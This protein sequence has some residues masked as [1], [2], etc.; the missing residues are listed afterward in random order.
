MKSYFLS[1]VMIAQSFNVNLF[2]ENIKMEKVE[3]ILQLPDEILRK[4]LSYV[5]NRRKAALV[6]SKMYETVCAVEMNKC[7][8]RV[9]DFKMAISCQHE[10]IE[11]IDPEE[12][13]L[14]LLC[15]LPSLTFKLFFS[16]TS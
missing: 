11:R 4:I 1:R 2:A 7:R 8:L 10:L 9:I 16:S 15:L 13:S 14:K 12:V 5:P 3:N 6:C